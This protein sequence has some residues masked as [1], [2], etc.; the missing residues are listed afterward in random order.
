MKQQSEAYD[1]AVLYMSIHVLETYKVYVE[2][3]RAI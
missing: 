3:H 2:E 1:S